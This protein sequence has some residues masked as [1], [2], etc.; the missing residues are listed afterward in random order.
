MKRIFTAMML[1]SG[2]MCY[3]QPQTFTEKIAREFTFE[4]KGPD[5]ALIVANINGDITV[6]GYNGDK[7]IVEI[8]KTVKGKTPERLEKG[9]KEVQLGVI[10]NA[11]TIVLY[12]EGECNKFGKTK[13]WND[14]DGNNRHIRNERW[15]YNWNNCNNCRNSYDYTMDFTIKV[16]ASLH[17]AVSTINDGNISIQGVG[18]VVQADNINGSIKLVNL[19]RE[20]VASTIN[21]DVDIEY[22]K[23]PLKGCRFY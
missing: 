23:N 14:E 7:V 9:K 6:V 8:T 12:V 16:P 2:V 5:N 4:K 10:D 1:L 22:D 21:G 19:T 17:V 11:D 13:D 3:A 15:G 20:T 18:G